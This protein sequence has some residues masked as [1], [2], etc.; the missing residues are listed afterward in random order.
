MRYIGKIILL[1]LCLA[2][3]FLTDC[4]INTFKPE[5]GLVYESVTVHPQKW[6]TGTGTVG[7]PWANDCLNSALT[8]CPAGGTIFLEA[9]YYALSTTLTITKQIN[10]I[11]EGINKSIIVLGMD[12]T[13]GIYINDEDYITFKGFTI[14]GASQ[15]D[16]FGDISC[17]RTDYCDYLTFEDIEVMN[18]GTIGINLFEINHSSLQNIYAH[19][20]YEHGVHPSSGTTGGNKLNNYQ[21]IYCWDNGVNGFDDYSS[22]LTGNNTYNNINGWDNGEHGIAISNQIGSVLSNSSASGNANSGIYL[23]AVKDS[24][25]NNCLFTLNGVKGIF[26]TDASENVNFKNVIVKNNF[27]GISIYNCIDIAFTSCQFYDDRE[28]PLQAYGIELYG[29]SKNISLVNCI[30][31]PNKKGEIYDSAGLY[32]Q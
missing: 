28:P 7:D 19:D 6:A 5:T 31:T 32:L 12:E 25:I 9:G 16:D 20:N 11:G 24:T 4:K 22:V 27:T 21:D 18:A 13:H 26:L 15:T 14:D 17:I 3:L 8:N 1:V 30:L 10:I 23:S 2:L 29:A